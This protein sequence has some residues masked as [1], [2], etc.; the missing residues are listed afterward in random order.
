MVN[1][2]KYMR[3]GDYCMRVFERRVRV[4][5]DREEGVQGALRLF[6]CLLHMGRSLLRDA[7]GGGGFPRPPMFS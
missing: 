7:M 4:K 3:V 2:E 1:I 5:G 6:F